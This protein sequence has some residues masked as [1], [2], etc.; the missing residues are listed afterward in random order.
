MFC[1]WA[2]SVPLCPFAKQICLQASSATVLLLQAPLRLALSRA[3]LRSAASVHL[4]PRPFPQLNLH[5]CPRPPQTRAATS[6]RL[7]RTRAERRL[8]VHSCVG[9]HLR[10]SSNVYQALTSPLA[11]FSPVVPKSVG[12]SKETRAGPEPQGPAAA[13]RNICA[14][15]CTFLSSTS[16]DRPYANRPSQ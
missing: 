11:S 7:N 8:S 10:L 5:K 2:R 14:G 3:K 15:A 16:P 13:L 12:S 1:L 6:K 9:T 4:T